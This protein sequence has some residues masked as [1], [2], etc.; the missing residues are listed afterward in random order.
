MIFRKKQSFIPV[1][2][3]LP[4]VGYR[5]C[6]VSMTAAFR[7]LTTNIPEEAHVYEKKH[8]GMAGKTYLNEYVAE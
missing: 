7:W 5:L 6:Y 2:F 3:F 8:D 1:I 4:W